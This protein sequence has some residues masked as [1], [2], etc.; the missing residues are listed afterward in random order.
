MHFMGRDS[1]H[2]SVSRAGS[3]RLVTRQSVR[4]RASQACCLALTASGLMVLGGCQKPLFPKSAPR[5]QFDNYDILRGTYVP[6]KT[7]DRSGRTRPAVR[8]RLE[9]IRGG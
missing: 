1:D 6:Q 2:N 5:T 8:E 3:L 4:T 7:T 9:R